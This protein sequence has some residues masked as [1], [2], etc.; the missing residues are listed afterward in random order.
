MRGLGRLLISGTAVMLMSVSVYAGENTNIGIYVN[1]KE[2]LDASAKICDG[3]TM[4]PIRF[5]AEQLGCQ[6]VWDNDSKN[7]TVKNN[8]ETVILTEGVKTI[9]VGDEK[10]EI[11]VAPLISEDRVYVPLRALSDGLNLDISW[12]E[13]TKTVS[14]YSAAAARQNY[15]SDYSKAPEAEL[16]DVYMTSSEDIVIPLNYDPNLEIVVDLDED[17]EK[18]CTVKEGFYDGRKALFIHSGER[19]TAGITLYYKGYD[20][21][22]YSR[23]YVNVY[24]VNGKEKALKEFDE[25][26]KTEG[27]YYKDVFS[28]IDNNKNEFENENGLFVFDRADDEYEKLFVG[29]KGMLIIP[30]DYNDDVQGVYDISY[31]V[32]SGIECKWGVYENKHAVM[33]TSD[34]YCTVPVRISFTE[35]NSGNVTFTI[36]DRDMSVEQTPY[37]N[38]YGN[39]NMQKTW[40]DFTVRAI[41]ESSYEL[42]DKIALTKDRIVYIK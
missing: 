37:V 16:T 9:K 23:T 39:N 40:W 25:M 36:T 35:N 5:I 13:M 34:K 8:G 21:T 20:S 28:E 10:S 19:G 12:N 32:N 41:S 14:V 4:V 24:V 1:G 26:L 42:R 31:D 6:V 2:V 29:D 7:V 30:V 3:Y 27:L 22:A 15:N 38:L 11:P 33:I 17:K 18:V